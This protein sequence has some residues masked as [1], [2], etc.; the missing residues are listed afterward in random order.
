MF[1]PHTS[2]YF[3]LTCLLYIVLFRQM[4][5]TTHT[6]IYCKLKCTFVRIRPYT[7]KI[8]GENNIKFVVARQAKDVYQYKN[9][10][11]KLHRTNAAIWH[12][13][14]CRQL[15]LTPKY[16]AIKVNGHNRQSRNTLKTA[17]EYRINQEL[18]Y[19]YIKKEAKR[20]TVSPSSNLC[21]K[22]ARE[23]AIY[24]S[25]VY[26][27][28]NKTIFCPHLCQTHYYPPQILYQSTLLCLPAASRS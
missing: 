20:T 1:F 12:N 11:E 19:L 22:L 23:L 18:K 15:Q 24:T 6:E 21:T 25:K 28:R 2:C 9:I 14:L 17:I 4:Y 10:T 3:H 13:K 5:T 27:C 26:I 16:I 7:I 8:Y